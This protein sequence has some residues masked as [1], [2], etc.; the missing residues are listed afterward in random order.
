MSIP[1]FH[2]K[3]YDNCR[4]CVTIVSVVSRGMMYDN[5]YNDVTIVSMMSQLFC[6]PDNFSTITT[7]VPDMSQLFQ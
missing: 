2:D 5:C 7:I 1:V 3:W 6:I 4:R